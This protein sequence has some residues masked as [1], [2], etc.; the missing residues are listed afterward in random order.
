MRP[1]YGVPGLWMMT[2][3]TKTTEAMTASSSESPRGTARVSGRR[4]NRIAAMQ[5][6]YMLDLNPVEDLAEAVRVFFSGRD[7]RRDYYSFAEELVFGV[8]ENLAGVDA[9]IA[10]AVRNWKFNRIAKVDLAILRLAIYELK[11][12][13]DIPPVVTINEAIEMGKLFSNAEAKRFI[14][15]VLDRVKDGLNRPL[16]TPAV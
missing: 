16:R 7:H 9:E 3:L 15:G 6:L 11:W 8:V 14:N 13:N 12:R 10:G 1:G 2:Q 5:F 4:E